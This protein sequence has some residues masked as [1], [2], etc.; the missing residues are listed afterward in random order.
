VHLHWI[1]RDTN[2]NSCDKL[3]EYASSIYSEVEFLNYADVK[4]CY[5]STPYNKTKATQVIEVVKE[6]L[7]GFYALLDQAKE[8][9]KPGFTIRPI[10]LISELD[11]ILKNNYSYEFQFI[12]IKVFDDIKDS[13]TIDC[14]VTHIDDKPA[15]D[16]ITEFARNKTYLS[17][18]LSARFNSAL[19]SLAFGNGDF[20]LARSGQLFST[21]NQLPK[22]PSISYTLSCNDKISKITRE[23]QVPIKH[24]FK[25]F[26]QYKSPY[27]TGSSV[28][29]ATL[30]FDAF[31]ARFYILEDFGVVVISTESIL[32]DDN[33]LEYHFLSN[34]V[35]GFKLLAD[36]GIKKIILDLSN[37]NGGDVFVA[38]YINKLLFPNIQ[39]FPVALKV[40]D[41]SIPFINEFSKLKLENLID[42]NA[43]R[44]NGVLF[45]YKSYISVKTNSAFNNV[46][47]FIGNNI[48]TRGG[49]QVKYTTKAFYDDTTLYVGSLK[50]PTPPKF[51][52]T[53][54]DIIILTNGIC[55][56]SCAIITQRLAEIN[57]PTISVG[58]FPN[59]P[60]SFAQ[61]AVGAATN[62]LSMNYMLANVKNI[63][64]SLISKLTFP[65][66]L[67]MSF[68]ILEAYSI[69]NPNEVMD[70]TVRRANYQL[71]YD[72]RSARD[73]SSLW[74]QA[75]NILK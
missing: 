64:P 58:G 17:R 12:Q 9:P 25:S 6:N 32:N 27:I 18:D 52:W 30:I 23:W 56:S 37:N 45:H 48:Y 43:N 26:M 24:K 7:K 13:S 10:D 39:N 22:S 67:I 53:E 75:A 5:E 11:L 55:H 8:E 70:Y 1:P 4:A 36:K 59:T 57:V 20:Q 54:K 68:T 33:D 3:T 73:P 74:M 46:T 31:I 21:R 41:N 29:K 66:N 2:A 35:T 47:D 61:Y 71:Y 65:T 50:P 72:E 42:L 28:G 16:V 40:N 69:N 60:F 44:M 14:Q 63:D 51:P 19:A 38:H 15:I 49:V 34:I 62:T